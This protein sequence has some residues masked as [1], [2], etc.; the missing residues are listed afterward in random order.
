M[1]LGAELAGFV[2]DVASGQPTKAELTSA[3]LFAIHTVRA[4]F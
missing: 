2:A 1:G 4:A 3:E